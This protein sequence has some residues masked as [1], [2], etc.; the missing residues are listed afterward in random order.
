M[1]NL[2]SVNY[3]LAPYT[4]IQTK[5]K[6]GRIMPALSTT[7]SVVSALQSIE[8][9]KIIKGSK[10]PKNTFANLAVPLVQMSEPGAAPKTKIGNSEISVWDRWEVKANTLKE[11]YQNLSETYDVQPVDSL[12]NGVVVYLKV[13]YKDKQKEE[14]T[15]MNTGLR[16]LLGLEKEDTWI[17]FT[18][19]FKDMKTG[20]QIHSVPAVRVLI[21]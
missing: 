5:L 11:L 15:L 18:I 9:I 10:S 21:P 16:E 2:R 7:T 20:T 13:T 4:W 3:S 6:A 19:S 1:A 14:E 12:V 17:D 8:L